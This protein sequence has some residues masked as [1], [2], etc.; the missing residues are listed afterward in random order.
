[1]DIRRLVLG[2]LLAATTSCA[3]R[4]SD[5]PA[6]QGPARAVFPMATRG[7]LAT[8]SGTPVIDGG[9]GSAIV[10]AGE[11]G[12]FL[13]LSD[14]GPNYD[15]AEDAKAFPRPDFVPRVGWFRRADSTLELVRVIE[16]RSAPGVPFSG[17]PNPQGRGGTGESALTVD[18]TPLT[19]DPNGLDPEGV[20]LSTDGSFWIADEYG[21]HLLHFDSTGLLIERF[22]P[23]DRSSLPAVLARRRPNRGLEGLTGT[24]DG[25]MLIAV[26]QSPLD[27]PKAAGR[28]SIHVRVV[29][30]EPATRRSRQYLYPVD[31][32]E[33]F[34][35]DVVR[36][37]DRI[38]LVIEHDGLAPRGDPP[39]T[40][41][42][43]YR[44]D[45]GGATDVSDPGNG[46]AGLLVNGKTLEQLTAAELASAG[47]RPV[48]KT[49]IADLLALGYSHDKPEGLV[50]LSPTE[51]GVVNDDDFGITDGPG[52]GGRPV[53][54][55]LPGSPVVD[56]ATFWIVR[57][58]TALW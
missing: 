9:F 50:I 13:A 3:A 31:R 35:S 40:Q 28:A 29:V 36:V 49:L 42:K 26:M 55:V 39:A 25:A 1:M 41:K 16:L 21:P 15:V 34:L 52:P 8:V 44:I 2:G 43:I 17:L 54:K 48:G 18:G 14:R 22:S 7:T 4:A 6:D 38:L 5:P 37:T 47:I 10:A 27:N 53:P 19:P 57:L 32:P 24:G 46:P 45:L 20:H 56:A 30:F 33:F 58:A 51:I 11:P 12:L 23:F